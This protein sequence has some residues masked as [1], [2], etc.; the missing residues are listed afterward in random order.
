MY[1]EV[2]RQETSLAD[3]DNVLTGV[4]RRI[5]DSEEIA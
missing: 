2:F 5:E 1:M 4:I 3:V